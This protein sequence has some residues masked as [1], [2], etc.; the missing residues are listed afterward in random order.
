MVIK[1]PESTL[2]LALV[3]PSELI[4]FANRTAKQSVVPA[5]LGAISVVVQAE[6]A[7]KRQA[8]LN[9]SG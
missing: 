9:S 5:D 2:V 4:V 3:R 6:Q 8:R 1:W 7:G